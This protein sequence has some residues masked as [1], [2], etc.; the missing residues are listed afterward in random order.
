MFLTYYGLFI[1]F[2]FV[3]FLLSLLTIRLCFVRTYMAVQKISF[4]AAC[5]SPDTTAYT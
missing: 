1:T 3:P 2:M 4:C 5:R